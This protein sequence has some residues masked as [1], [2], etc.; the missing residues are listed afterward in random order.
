MGASIGVEE[1]DSFDV[2]YN[3]DLG[4]LMTQTLCTLTNI[5]DVYVPITIS[6]RIS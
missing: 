2:T 6:E 1:G 5:S 4:M 3:E